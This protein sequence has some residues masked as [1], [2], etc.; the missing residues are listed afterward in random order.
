MMQVE[1]LY[2][3]AFALAKVTMARGDEVRAEAGAMVSMNQYLEVETKAQGG[4]LKSLSRSMLGGESFFMNTFK[5]TND[6]AELTLAPHLPG[7]I[8]LMEMQGRDFIVQ[9]GSYL[10]SDT[11]VDVDTKWGG[12]RTFFGGEGLFMLR[13]SGNGTLIVSSYGAIHKV[14][15]G[16]GEIY[17]VDSGHIVAFD[18][19]IPYEI[20]K[21]GSWKSTIFGGEGLMVEFTGPGNLYLQ[22][23]SPSAFISWLA[24]LL[25]STNNNS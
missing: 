11:K 14:V 1:I 9:S 21:V 25:P 4:F 3:P 24:P 16:E 22:T 19:H 13:C 12:A 8:M 6:G 10:A 7:D 17:N 2:Q 20:R 5:A 18:A 23:R 15:L